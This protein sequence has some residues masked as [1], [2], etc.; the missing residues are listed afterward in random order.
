M[1]ST[2]NC[3]ILLSLLLLLLSPAAAFVP[4]I[5]S[6]VTTT[7]LTATIDKAAVVI[8]KKAPLAGS[9]PKWE[10][11]PSG[12]TQAEFLQSDMSLPDISGMWEC[13]LT[14]WDSDG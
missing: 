4:L 8:E 2:S 3:W 12:L 14:R 1:V 10:D 11:R 13:P 6:H 7:R 5:S 9:E